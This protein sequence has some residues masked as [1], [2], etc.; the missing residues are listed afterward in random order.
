LSVH[1]EEIWLELQKSN[2]QAASS[3]DAA[4]GA[5]VEELLAGEEQPPS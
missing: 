3:S 2:A 5:T 1:R 4:I